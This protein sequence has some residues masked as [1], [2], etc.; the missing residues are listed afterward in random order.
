MNDERSAADNIEKVDTLLNTLTDIRASVKQLFQVSTEESRAIDFPQLFNERLR[1]VKGIIGRF[2]SEAENAQGALEYAHNLSATKTFDLSTIVR[3]E[4]IDGMDYLN[5]DMQGN[6]AGDSNKEFGIALKQ[7]ASYLLREITT[8]TPYTLKR[9]NDIPD[10]RDAKR[11]DTR[12]DGNPLSSGMISAFVNDWI[13]TSP[14]SKYADIQSAIEESTT[15]TGSACCLKISIS[16]V[17]CA[18]LSVQYDEGKHSVV[19][20]NFCVVAYREEKPLWERSDYAVFEKI[21]ILAMER[22]DEMAKSN[23]QGSVYSVLNW[24]ASYHDLFTATCHKCQ[25][26]LLFNSPQFKYLP[27]TLR[28]LKQTEND[29]SIEWLAYHSK[30]I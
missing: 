24:I 4:P 26:R 14:F 15:L 30:C 12:E 3:D 27:P 19:F 7:N 28:V 1:V 16:H 20:D 23:A 21:N 25:K 11:I 22:L 6:D 13:K 5:D 10:E 8:S 2:T 9:L 17:L 29:D 18:Y